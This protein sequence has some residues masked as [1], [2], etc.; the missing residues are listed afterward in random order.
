MWPI[1][2]FMDLIHMYLLCELLDVF[3]PG[4]F[5]LKINFLN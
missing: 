4:L 2:L 1:N 5:R 3:L